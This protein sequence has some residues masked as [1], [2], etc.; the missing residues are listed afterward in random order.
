MSN[1]PEN[2]NTPSIVAQ[3][4]AQKEKLETIAERLKTETM[5]NDAQLLQVSQALAI[6][7]GGV[8]I[9]PETQSISYRGLAITDA[10]YRYWEEVGRRP[11]SNPELTRMLLER[12]WETNSKNPAPVIYATLTSSGKWKRTKDGMFWEPKEPKAQRE[13]GA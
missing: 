4:Q 6:L 8:V 10:A 11:I 7:E 13:R 2:G 5:E 1:A 3:L 12:G 9:G